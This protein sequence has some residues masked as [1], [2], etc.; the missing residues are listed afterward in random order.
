DLPE[1]RYGAPVPPEHDYRTAA[2]RQPTG[3]HRRMAANKK[4]LSLEE[5]A[6]V[7]GLR[8]DEVIRLREKGELR[9]FADRGT[10]KFKSD[11][12]DEAKRRRQ[13]VSNPDVPLY[14][15]E[16]E[17]VMSFD[18]DLGAQATMVRGESTSDSDVRLVLD[19]P[20]AGS[21]AEVPVLKGPGSDSDV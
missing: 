19:A 17:S 18:E 5:A 20:L 9:G 21:S 3:S 12:V 6:Q 7:M 2:A 8:T 10:W 16:S 15:G 11:D 4:Y 1:A 13:P 14:S